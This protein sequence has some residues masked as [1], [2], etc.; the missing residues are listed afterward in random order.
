MKIIS[1]FKDCYDSVL[2]MGQDPN[3]VYLR[4]TTDIEDKDDLDYITDLIKNIPDTSFIS[5]WNR[6]TKKNLPTF[7]F[8]KKTKMKIK[9]NKFIWK[10]SKEHTK[11]N[12]L[13]INYNFLDEIK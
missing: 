12:H 5:N 9:K 13:K 2:A 10:N 1:K 6:E 4:H 8:L 3:I 11:P 7:E